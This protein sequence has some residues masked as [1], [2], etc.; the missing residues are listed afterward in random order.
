M[1]ATRAEGQHSRA[2][3]ALHWL[4]AALILTS[5]VGGWVVL[6]GKG[7]ADPSKLGSLARHMMVG[8]A[9]GLVTL[10][11]L[12]VR[13]VER[14]AARRRGRGGPMAE[15]A[16]ADAPATLVARLA[17]ALHALSY[18]F[19]LTMVATGFATVISTGLN[20]AVFGGGGAIPESVATAVAAS[21][22][23]AVH[24]F[25]AWLVFGFIALHAGAVV[26][27]QLRGERILGRMLP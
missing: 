3:V 26:W 9:I 11:R 1:G 21:P 20:D 14:R 17:P 15:P 18:V 27:H 6:R 19:V 23:R 7:D 22:T 2:L 8:A 24:A 10:A 16:V 4:A 12:G 25:V 5:L 13:F